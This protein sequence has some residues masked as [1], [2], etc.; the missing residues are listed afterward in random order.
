MSL[1]ERRV[2]TYDEDVLAV[3]G[4]AAGGYDGGREQQFEAISENHG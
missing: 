2:R 3:G 1:V 4:P